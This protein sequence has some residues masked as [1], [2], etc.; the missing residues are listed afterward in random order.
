MAL[1]CSLAQEWG[2]DDGERAA[3]CGLC[4]LLAGAVADG[5][6]PVLHR[7]KAPW[8]PPP[9][10]LSGAPACSQGAGLQDLADGM[11]AQVKDAKEGMAKLVDPDIERKREEAAKL[12]WGGVAAVPATAAASAQPTPAGSSPGGSSGGQ[13]AAA[14]ATATAAPVQLESLSVEQLEAELQRRKAA[15]AAQVPKE[16]RADD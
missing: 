9:A 10:T 14:T 1:S 15:A 6:E 4:F 12:A 13:L 16:L 8:E 2:R 3:A 7:A 5:V 11:T